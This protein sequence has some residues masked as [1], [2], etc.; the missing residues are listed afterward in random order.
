MEN[1]KALL[2]R[3]IKAKNF[4]ENKLNEDIISDY[5]K[6]V[7]NVKKLFANAKN[8]TY[9]LSKGFQYVDP[10]KIKDKFSSEKAL[11]NIENLMVVL[12]N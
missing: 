6:V 9:K 10:N 7:S 2:N 5:L 4:L 12:E 8:A 11:Q 1:N 3:T